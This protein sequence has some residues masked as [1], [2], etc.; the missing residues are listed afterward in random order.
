MALSMDYLGKLVIVLVAVAVSVSMIIEFRGQ[1]EGTTP[2]PGDG[3]DPGLEIVQ[4]EESSSL[5]KVAD[6]IT[7]CHQR[8]LE[9][10]YEDISCFVAR[11][12]SGDFDLNSTDLQAQLSEDVNQSTEFQ[13]SNY[14]RSSIIIQYKVSTQKVV[15]KE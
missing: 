3:E 12:N 11:K 7:L 13:A 6:L 10:G 2:N 8:S 5:S 15:V 4:V 1:I 14:D 9:Q